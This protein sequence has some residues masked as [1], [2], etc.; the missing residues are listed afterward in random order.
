[1]SKPL[2]SNSS[3]SPQKITEQKLWVSEERFRGAFEN[4]PTGM[5]LFD[6]TGAIFQV[7]RAFCQMLG[8]SESSLFERRIRDLVYPSDWM[9]IEKVLSGLH[10]GSCYKTECRFFHG[11]GRLI[12]AQLNVSLLRND[13]LEVLYYI[14][15]IQDITEQRRSENEL[16]RALASERHARREAEAANR[17]KDEF[18]AVISHELRTPLTAILGWSRM[19]LAN[20]LEDG[21]KSYALQAIDRNARAQAQL[22]EDILDASR[23]IT[24]NLKL[25]VQTTNLVQLVKD[26]MESVRPLAV[27]KEVQ[28]EMESDPGETVV[29]GDA[30]RLQQVVWNLLSNA[31]KFT[32]QGGSVSIRLYRDGDRARIRVTDTGEGI[33]PEFL[34]FVFDRFRQADSSLTR[35]HGG[36]GLGLSIVRHL[37]ELHGGTVEAKSGGRDMGS[38]FIVELPLLVAKQKEKGVYLENVNSFKRAYPSL[39]NIRVLVVDDRQDTL[40]FLTV[41][42][43]NIGAEV[44]AVTSVCSAIQALQTWHPHLLLSDIEM[45][46]EDGYQLIRKVRESSD[47]AVNSIPA[48][49]L[50]GHARVEDEAMCLEEG[51]NRHMSKPVDLMGLAKAISQMVEARA[52]FQSA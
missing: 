24:G 46:Y 25:E 15:Q 48:I 31:I 41:F 18:L 42:L 32:P 10:S 19:V 45:P 6:G 43:T 26:A 37:V 23:I 29:S 14:A 33:T 38:E 9:A 22:V 3:I 50:T 35:E 21:K 39:V 49:A 13:Q 36:L 11:S 52:H 12:A 30:H 7:N 44:K 28:L 17:M 47:A 40:K 2:Q 5:A 8:S 20:D 27:L 1:M 16:E 51:Y 4:A 34:P